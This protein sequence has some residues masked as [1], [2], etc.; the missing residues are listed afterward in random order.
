MNHSSSSSFSFHSHPIHRYQEFMY[1]N[2]SKWE[3]SAVWM[4]QSSLIK[5]EIIVT[6]LPMMTQSSITLLLFKQ[7]KC[8]KFFVKSFKFLIMDSSL[9]LVMY[10]FSNCFRFDHRC[11]QFCHQ[12]TLSWFTNKDNDCLISFC[13]DNCIEKS[14]QI[15]W[16]SDQCAI[17]MKLRN[18]IKIDHKHVLWN[19]IIN[20][21]MIICELSSELIIFESSK[22]K[23]PFWDWE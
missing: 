7:F 17:I 22:E 20:W 21:S 10:K 11:S 4:I 13:N 5:C 9:I 15:E 12:N 23:C 8:V 14:P 16:L 18:D 19:F 1:L 2:E 3:Y 6:H